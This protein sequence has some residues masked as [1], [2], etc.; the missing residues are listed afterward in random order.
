MIDALRQLL[1]PTARR[2]LMGAAP[3]VIN[4]TDDTTDHQQ[5]QVEA[6]ADEVIDDV[7][8]LQPYGFASRAKAG[9]V[10][11]L[12]SVMGLRSQGIVLNVGDH[13]YRLKGL[14]EGEVALYDDQGQ[15]VKIARTGIQITT[16]QDVDVTATGTGT[17]TVT[18]T[19]VVIASSDIRLGGSGATKKIA[20][21][22]DSVTGSH[23]VA[24]ST[25]VKAL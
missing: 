3:V 10:G 21:D 19:T 11:L 2:G 8:H 6:L 12:L 1:A 14:D 25:T 23:V 13:R 15:V 20:L 9:A 7:P 5:A 17:V 22:G 18:A 24:T 16:G 4:L